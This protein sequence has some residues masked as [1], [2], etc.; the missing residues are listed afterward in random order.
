M[1]GYSYGD[2]S[3]FQPR[4]IEIAED[5]SVFV[6]DSKN[7]RV[8]KFDENFSFI[9]KWGTN[10]GAGG[11]GSEGSGPGEFS[12][13]SG[14]VVTPDGLVFVSDSFNHRISKFQIVSY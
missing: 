3:F 4:S 8:Q 12:Y 11:I 9:T 13:P 5:G 2:G 14:V 10:S 1:W 6:V 7:S